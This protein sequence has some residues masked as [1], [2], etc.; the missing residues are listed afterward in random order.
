MSSDPCDGTLPAPWGPNLGP[1]TEPGGCGR[2][3]G[4]KGLC[5]PVEL[6]IDRQEGTS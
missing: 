3:A 6:A 5:H 1:R 2:P 4:H